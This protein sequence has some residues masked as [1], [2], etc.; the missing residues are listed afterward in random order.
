MAFNV[1]FK[2]PSRNLGKSDVEFIVRQNSSVLGTLTISKGTLVWFPKGTNTGYRM[3]W[4]R[5]NSLMKKH[6]KGE[7]KR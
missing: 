2:V 4:S 5:F 6:A 1:E 7:E 3:G